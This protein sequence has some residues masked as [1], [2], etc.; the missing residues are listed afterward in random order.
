MKLAIGN[1][2]AIQLRKRITKLGI[3]Q[4][5]LA[6]QIN[7]S[8]RYIRDILSTQKTKAIKLDTNK[9]EAILALLGIGLNQVFQPNLNTFSSQQPYLEK[10]IL[11]LKRKMHDLLTKDNQENLIFIT[12][13]LKEDSSINKT[14]GFWYT[15]ILE[16]ITNRYIVVNQFFNRNNFFNIIPENGF[17]RKFRHDSSSKQNFYFSFQ[18]EPILKNKVFQVAYTLESPIKIN[19]LLPRR[20]KIIYG[21]IKILENHIIIHQYH[22]TPASYRIPFT[23]DLIVTTWLDSADH[24]FII[25]S[26]YDFILRTEGLVETHNFYL[27]AKNKNE[28]SELFHKL[29]TALFPRNHLFHRQGIEDMGDDPIFFWNNHNFRSYNPTN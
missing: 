23:K 1:Q 6:M 17:W 20:I 11:T 15:L 19:F 12:K 24:D 10:Y 13:F 27:G 29:G 3:T 8:E 26:D 5:E 14:M 21:E 4:K 25:T 18:L 9:L 16:T 22:D 2:E 28:V 7:V